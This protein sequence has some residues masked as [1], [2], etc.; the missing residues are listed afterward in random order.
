MKCKI[1]LIL[2]FFFP[3]FSSLFAGSHKVTMM[4]EELNNTKDPDKRITLLIDIANELKGSL[5]DSALYYFTEAEKA[6]H[7]LATNPKELVTIKVMVGR[8]SVEIA[9]GNYSKARSLDS[10]AMVKA[11]KL[12]NREEQAKILM[13]QGSVYYN[14][15]DFEK[16]QKL[17]WE[18]L[19]I[20]RSTTDRKTEGKI[21]TNMGTIEFM[22]G[23]SDKADSLFK[24]PLLIA[25]KLKDDDLLAASYLNIGLLNVYMSRY[26]KAEK[27]LQKATSVYQS[28]DGK[29]GLVLC[30]QNLSNI[31][32]EKGDFG[33]A[34][35]NNILNQNLSLE[36]GDKLGLSKAYQNLGECHLQIGDYEKALGFYIKALKIKTELGDK[37]GIAATNSSI[38][39]IHYMRSERVL[40]MEYYRESLKDNT[41]IGYS[42]GVAAGYSDIGTILS[43]QNKNDSALYFF[44]KAQAVYLKGNNL[45]LLSNVYL[46]IGK[47]LNQKKDFTRAKAF[48]SKAES[49][50]IQLDDKPGIYNA[51]SLFSTIYYNE[52]LSFPI[53]SPQKAVKLKLS[54]NYALKAYTVAESTKNLPGKE[55]AA[56]HL[57]DLYSA[58]GNPVQ[59]LKY[60][61]IKIRVSD[62]LSLMQREAALVNA[63]IR[64]K[65]EKK[66]NEINQ[67]QKEKALQNIVIKQKDT[68]AER[69]YILVSVILLALLLIVISGILYVKNKN[70]SKNIEY[71]KRLNEI[72]RLKMQNINNR[73]SPHL[74]FNVLNTVS[75][76][77]GNPL[78][79][80][81]QID[82]ISLLLRRSLESTEQIAIPLSDEIEMVKTYLEL[83]NSRIPQP[84]NTEFHISETVN[85][86]DLIPPMILQI[87]VENAIKHGLMPLEGSK[88]LNINIKCNDS[89]IEIH[90]ADNGIGRELSKGRTTGTGTGLKV[91]LQ[92]IKLLNQNNK[93]FITFDISDGKQQGTLIKI[94][95][96]IN[97]SYHTQN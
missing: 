25:E 55:D 90:V 30:Y 50:K 6:S 96:P 32:F 18:A 82:Q 49:I 37:K 75:G 77:A 10:V 71:Q 66:Q 14:Q 54:L 93:E 9:K 73:L 48:I 83:Q 43:E 62:S 57:I 94:C 2:F 60:A 12:K 58:S 4:I 89:K 23:N 69:L 35:E 7:G 86:N 27:Y 51:W 39:H 11:L 76:D 40:A 85:L 34:I 1:I 15:S 42:M 46:N 45:N 22:F 36:I 24:L 16:A 65:A 41:E 61:K 20:N 68:L 63:E 26:D 78:K 91:L 95:V 47:T 17:N 29:D 81:Q 21:L 74:F 80:K 87:P 64:W 31:Y 59:A 88:Q 79:V 84:F 97:Y 53:S 92:T 72:I 33:K 52:Y 8:A 70:K 44:A 19:C 67:L 56:G 13:S 3:F 5:P 28:I 38:G